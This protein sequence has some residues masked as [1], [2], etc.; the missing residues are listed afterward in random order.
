MSMGRWPPE[1]EV[2]LEHGEPCVY[3]QTGML[4]VLAGRL[5]VKSDREVSK[6]G[7]RSDS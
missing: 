2:V 4:A 6:M 1:C 7:R 5:I 3:G